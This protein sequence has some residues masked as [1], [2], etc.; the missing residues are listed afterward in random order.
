MD[1]QVQTLILITTIFFQASG[2]NAQA[3]AKRVLTF[4]DLISMHRLADPQISPD[5]QW[6]AYGV[7][8]PNYDANTLSHEIWIV[9]S[10]GGEPRQLTHDESAERPRWSPDGTRVAFLSSRGGAAQVFSISP[11]GGEA[12]AISS[13][14]TGA[15]NEVWS[16]DGKTIAF[17]SSVYPDCDN[18]ACNTARDAEKARSQVKA[19]VYTKLLYRH[20][21]TWSG[22]KRSH[23]FLIPA[24]GGTARDLTPGAD[25]DVPPFTLDNTE[26][27]AFSPDSQ[28]ICFTAN[29]DEDE[30]LSTNGDLFIVRLADQMAS[31]GYRVNLSRRITSNPGNDWGPQYSPDGKTIAYRAQ[32]QAGH[33]SDRW[34]LILYDRETGKS[35]NRT[36]NYAGN[37]EAFAWA[38]DSKTIYFETEEQFELPIE[39]IAVRGTGLPSAVVAN[40][41]NGDFDISRD[42]RTLVFTRS[43]L[44]A[45]A[46]IFAAN[47]D[48]TNV[49]QLTHQN[50]ALVLQLDLPAGE[51]F[52]FTGATGT[53]VQ[54]MFQRPPNFDPTKKYPLLLLLHGGPQQEWDD[55]WGYRWNSQLMA[56]PGYVVLMINSR[57]VPGYGP[58]FVDEVSRDWGGKVYEDTMK[59]LDAAISKY[60]FIDSKR[61]AAAGGSFGGYTV[62]WMATHTGL[63]K[64]LISHAGPWDETAMYGSTEELWFMNWELGG[65]PWSNPEDYRK[66]SASEYAGALAK[67]RTPTLVIGGELD[68]RI[69]Y[70]QELEFFTALQREG[71]P[72]KLVIF[73]DEG[74]WILKPQNSEFWYKT[75]L[76]WLATYLK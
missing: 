39:K 56:T 61:L 34:R 20:W 64:C 17:V 67:Y 3:P 25:Y 60:S 16:P 26:A 24:G 43:S 5:G 29:T 54:A 4:K 33:E 10:A 62:D 40:S 63:F 59:G 30:A 51:K 41:A 47:S 76:D 65:P 71:V 6:V 55:S 27:I 57:G 14:S 28:E 36:E 70:T 19:R 50:S 74:H 8:T 45:P 31:G 75:F 7:A 73:P 58:T 22:G 1:W 53:Q 48:G 21:D 72:S 23:L 68:F 44:T 46:E 18:D 13:I 2:A 38:Q 52:W 69:P 42:G 35:T 15:G 37:V 9:P 12:I 66:W 32:L 49:R 11:S